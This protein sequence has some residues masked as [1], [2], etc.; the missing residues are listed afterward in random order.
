VVADKP[1]TAMVATR[2]RKHFAYITSGSDAGVWVLSTDRK[3]SQKIYAPAA[4]AADT[5]AET[6]QSAVWSE[7]GSHLLIQTKIGDTPNYSVVSS[8]GGQATNLTKLFKFD[9]TSITFS[10]NDWSDMYWLSPEGLRRLNVDNKT[11]SAVLAEKVKSFGFA[12]NDHLVFVQSTPKGI[13]LVT[14]DRSGQNAKQLV[15]AVA[16]SPSYQM[17]YSLYRGHDYLSL[18]PQSTGT[19]TVY[20]DLFTNNVASRVVSHNVGQVITSDNGQLIG[21]IDSEGF[22]A[23]NLDDAL[24]YSSKQPGATGLAWFDEAHVLFNH[25]GSA[26]VAEFDGGNTTGVLD[27]AADSPLFGSNDKRQVLCLSPLATNG[28][29]SIL[30]VDLKK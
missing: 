10:P 22:G 30:A 25:T 28:N 21:F 1:V 13:G 20:S 2:D 12:G 17:V 29:R 18:L 7:D 11:V 15:E 19:L 5:P 24:V 14:T 26:T 4:A 23:Y 3:Q 16:D 9:F 8:G 27:C 6:I